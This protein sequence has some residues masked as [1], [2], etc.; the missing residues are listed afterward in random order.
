MNNLFIILIIGVILVC[1]L[2]IV[3]YLAYDEEMRGV[4]DRIENTEDDD[5]YLF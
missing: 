2:G 5:D 3:F 1:A 4:V